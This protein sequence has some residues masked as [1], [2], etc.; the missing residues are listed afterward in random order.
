MSSHLF[1]DSFQLRRV[2]PL[3]QNNLQEQHENIKIRGAQK[4]SANVILLQSITFTKSD[5]VCSLAGPGPVRGRLICL[6]PVFL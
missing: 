1:K 3:R 4:E 2:S 6:L 5:D